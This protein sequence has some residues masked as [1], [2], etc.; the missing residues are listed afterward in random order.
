VF[1]QL[2][3]QVYHTYTTQQRGVEDLTSFDAFLD[4]TPY[5]RQQDF[6][7]S[8]AGWPQHPTYG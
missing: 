4:I 2:D 3:G 8:P 1:F 6:E 5:G 7:D